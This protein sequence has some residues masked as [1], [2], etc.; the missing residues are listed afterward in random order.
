[1]RRIDVDAPKVA[2]QGVLSDTVALNECIVGSIRLWLELRQSNAEFSGQ[3]LD[4]NASAR[5][6]FGRELDQVVVQSAGSIQERTVDHRIDETSFNVA[7]LGQID[8]GECRHRL[9]IPHLL[10]PLHFIS[11]GGLQPTAGTRVE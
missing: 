6:I 11:P 4:W 8:L 5:I 3:R 2:L 1:L 9:V 7:G 10:V